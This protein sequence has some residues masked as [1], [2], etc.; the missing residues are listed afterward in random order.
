MLPSKVEPTGDGNAIVLNEGNW[1]GNNSSLSKVN[2]ATGAIG[3]NVFSAA[4]GRGLGDVAQD[5][6]V[7]GTK[8]YVTVSFSNTIEAMSLDDC[9]SVQISL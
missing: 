5:V 3:N 7:Y 1:S 6:V 2:L 9:S 8:A 4:N